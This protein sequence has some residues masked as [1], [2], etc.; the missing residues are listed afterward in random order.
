MRGERVRQLLLSRGIAYQTRTHPLAYTA[1]EVAATE[2][3]PG[4]EIAKPVVLKV[5]GRMVM[6]VLPGTK[7]VSLEKAKEAFDGEVALAK[8]EEFARLFPDCERGAEP[9]FGNLYD[10]PVYLDSQL[11]SEHIT[12]NAGTHTETIRMAL[13]DYRRLVNPTTVDI[14]S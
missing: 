8:E 12:F 13:D 11:E 2:H 1:Q 10:L 5:D 3:I 4:K 7:R 14:A 6:A 9:P